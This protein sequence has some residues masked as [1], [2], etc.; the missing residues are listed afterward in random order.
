M[1]FIDLAAQQRRIADNLK[2]RIASVLAHGQYING[3]EVLELEAT[4]AGYVGVKHAVGCA[5][6]TD[7]LLMALM[8]LD[9]GPGDAVFTTPFTFVATAEVISLI[10]ATPLFVDIDPIT[11]NIDPK[12]L[13]HAILTLKENPS[14]LPFSDDAG[15][16][17]PGREAAQALPRD[18]QVVSHRNAERNHTGGMTLRPRAVI[19]VDLFG[20]PADYDAIGAVAAAHGLA[21]IADAAQSFGSDYKGK[22]ACAFGEIACTSFF[23]AKPLGCY[24]DGGMCFTN[25]DH[26]DG[27]LRSIRVH[28]QGMDKYENVRIGIN[29]RLDTLQAAILLAKFSIFPEEIDLRQEVAQRYGELLADAVVTPVIPDGYKSVWAQ[30]SLLTRDAAERAALMGALKQDGV[31]TAVYYPKPL[32]LQKAFAHAGYREGDF[33]V[34]E[35]CAERIF[36]LPMHPYLDAGQ[37]S[38]I[39]ETLKRS[40]GK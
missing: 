9:I 28:G 32:H 26:L 14:R 6:G 31:P 22:K 20:L 16:D 10:G 2:A 19:P 17:G 36:S 37:Q 4:L 1:D 13:E 38:R 34:S 27:I 40:S 7:A 21:V 33:P 12:K 25:D 29:G 15:A 30:Y 23:P 35:V 11:F 18:E 8:A 39:A 24:G 5:S 3:P